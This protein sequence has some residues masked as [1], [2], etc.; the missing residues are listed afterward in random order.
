MLQGSK[1][2][3]FIM[4]GLFRD[5]QHVG[6]MF[7]TIYC[8]ESVQ[9]RSYF[10]SVF[11][12][13]RAEYGEIRSEMF[14]IDLLPTLFSLHVGICYTQR[15][16]CPKTDIFCSVF[17]CIRT[18]KKLLI[19]TLF[20]QWQHKMLMKTGLKQCLKIY[21]SFSQIRLLFKINNRN[22]RTIFEICLNLTIKTPERL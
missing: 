14:H 16:N 6:W 22:S 7:L 12:R 1:R 3:A 4:S 17:S 5:N 9:I 21:L 8:V 18:K 15:E 10:W 2:S 19:G 11:S 13:I 20:M